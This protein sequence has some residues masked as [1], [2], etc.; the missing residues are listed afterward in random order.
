MD[1]RISFG[2][3]SVTEHHWKHPTLSSLCSLSSS[4]YIHMCNCSE[5]APGWIV[6]DLPS[7]SPHR[8]VSAVPWSSWWPS[9]GIFPICPCY[10]CTGRSKTGQFCTPCQ[11]NW[12]IRLS[13]LFFYFCFLCCINCYIGEE[14]VYE[15]CK[16]YRFNKKYLI[17]M[18]TC[19]ILSLPISSCLKDFCWEEKCRPW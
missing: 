19:I 12:R 5:P 1:V 6:P 14:D 16:L 3:F 10:P 17:R 9:T 15:D 18:N 11:I 4:I 2:S 8:R 7:S 13:L